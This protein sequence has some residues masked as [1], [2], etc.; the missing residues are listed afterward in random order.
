MCIYLCRRESVYST[1]LPGA[2]R[3]HCT[4]GQKSSVLSP[5]G[6]ASQKGSHLSIPEQ[7]IT[8]QC[9][10]ARG[11]S[12]LPQ[13]AKQGLGGKGTCESAP[14]PHQHSQIRA[15]CSAPAHPTPHANAAARSPHRGRPAPLRGGP[16]HRQAS[17]RCGQWTPLM[18]RCARLNCAFFPSAIAARKVGHSATRCCSSRPVRTSKMDTAAPPVQ[19]PELGPGGPPSRTQRRLPPATLL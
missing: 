5:R 2:S 12:T 19:L 3:P 11:I 7:Q 14:S 8:R 17:H 6:E 1:T 16:G 9:L 13:K 18:R 4:A 15:K 10:P